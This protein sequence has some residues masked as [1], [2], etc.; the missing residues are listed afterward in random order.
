MHLI[1]RISLIFKLRFV[2][3][4]VVNITC[5][6]NSVWHTNIY[7]AKVHIPGNT[8]NSTLGLVYLGIKSGSLVVSQHSNV[9]SSFESNVSDSFSPTSP[10]SNWR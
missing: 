2:N 8:A 9:G 1:L 4:Q 5:S 6:R 3:Q 7:M 10:E